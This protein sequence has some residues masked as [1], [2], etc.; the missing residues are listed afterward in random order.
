MR[1]LSFENEFCIQFHF[2][3]NQSQF[4]HK[5]SFALTLTWKQRHKG[6]RKWPTRVRMCYV[7]LN[8]FCSHHVLGIVFIVI[9][10]CHSNGQISGLHC[11]LLLPFLFTFS[12][13]KMSL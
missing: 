3:V 9:E 12:L 1:N 10:C 4:F 6:T 7:A 5:N 2:H 8:V 13:L 11:L